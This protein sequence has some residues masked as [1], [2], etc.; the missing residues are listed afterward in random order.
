MTTPWASGETVSGWRAWLASGRARLGDGLSRHGDRVLP[1]LAAIL[2]GLSMLLPYWRLALHAPQYPRGLNVDLSLTDVSGDVQEVDGLNHYIGMRP[3]EEGGEFEQSAALIA[4]PMVALL[5]AAAAV[6]RRGAWLLALPAVA[7]PVVFVGDLFY[8]LY[9][10][11]HDLDPTAALSSSIDEFT[12]S[13]L[14]G[15]QVAQMTTT[16]TFQAGFY[17]AVAA[18]VLLV[19]AGVIRRRR[20]RTVA[21]A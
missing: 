12:P 21:P 16:S 3:L 13:L 9:S 18:A 19:G 17:L 6:R 7:L 15:G 1:V 5:A 8:W 4:V 2:I 10:F 11:G 14:G 20:N